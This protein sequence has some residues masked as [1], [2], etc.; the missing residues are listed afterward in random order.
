MRRSNRKR[1]WINTELGGAIEKG[2]G[3][4]QNEEEQ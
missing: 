4:T 2:Y 1:V 3:L